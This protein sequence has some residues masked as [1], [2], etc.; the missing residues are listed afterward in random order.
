MFQAHVEGREFDW[1][2]AVFATSAIH[3]GSTSRLLVPFHLSI[4]LKQVYSWPQT[5]SDPRLNRAYIKTMQEWTRVP[6]RLFDPPRHS[7]ATDEGV[8]PRLLWMGL[9]GVPEDRRP[10]RMPPGPSLGPLVAPT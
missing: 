6:A 10:T 7:G 3:Q 1:A 2:T 5:A 4:P 8:T 9:P